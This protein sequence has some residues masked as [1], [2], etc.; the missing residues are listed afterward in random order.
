MTGIMTSAVR[1]HHFR[2]PNWNVLSASFLLHRVYKLYNIYCRPKIS[3]L[4]YNSFSSHFILVQSTHTV[5][6]WYI[7]DVN[8]TLLSAGSYKLV[9][10]VWRL[11]CLTRRALN[12]KFL[13]AISGD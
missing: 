4:I 6:Q 5:Y 13:L 10:S 2:F 11:G 1:L 9:F 7:L 8:Y 12:L 3:H